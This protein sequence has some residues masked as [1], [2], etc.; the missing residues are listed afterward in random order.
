M[1]SERGCNG[2]D[3]FSGEER[4]ALFVIEDGD[5]QAPSALARDAPVGARIEHSGEARL[6][7]VGDEADAVCNGFL[8]AIAEGEGFGDRR[9][10]LT[11]ILSGSTALTAGRRKDGGRSPPYGRSGRGSERERFIDCDKP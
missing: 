8:G 3:G 7:P 5:R 1:L 9:I 4:F 11:P 2:E 10:T 6:T